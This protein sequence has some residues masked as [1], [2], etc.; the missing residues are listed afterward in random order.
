MRPI[1]G[2][3]CEVR[4]KC[5]TAEQTKGPVEGHVALKKPLVKP[6]GPGDLRLG[7]EK[8]ASRISASVKGAHKLCCK[9]TGRV[10]PRVTMLGSMELRDWAFGPSRV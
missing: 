8:I 7:M 10:L 2:G 5:C 6:S 9:V 1:S 4:K 3:R